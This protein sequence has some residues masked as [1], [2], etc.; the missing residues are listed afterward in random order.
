MDRLGMLQNIIAAKP[1]EPFPRYGLAMEYKR[2]GRHDEALAAFEELARLHPGYVPGYLMHGNLLATLERREQALAVY[3]RGIAAAV[4][5][6]DDHAEGEL[7]SARD[8][9]SEGSPPA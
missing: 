5:A 6:G 1:G 3:E 4:A 9:L 8:G 7:R 2:L